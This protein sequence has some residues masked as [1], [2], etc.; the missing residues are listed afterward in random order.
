MKFQINSKEFSLAIKPVI[1][2]ATK[3][4]IKDYKYDNKVTIQALKDKII[5]F[6]YNGNA[7]IIAPISKDNFPS[8]GYICEEEGK[9]TV[10]ATN[11]WSSLTTIPP[12]DVNIEEKSGEIV[13]SLLSDNDCKR[14]HA[15]FSDIIQ[16]PNIGKKFAYE[17]TVDRTLFVKG[18]EDVV[19]APAFEEKMMTYMCMLFEVSDGKKQ[20]LRFSAGTGGRFAVKIIDGKDLI[21]NSSKVDEKIIFPKIHLSLIAKNLHETNCEKI[22]IRTVSADIQNNIPEQI[23]IEFNGFIMCLLGLDSFTKYPPLMGVINHKYTNRIYSDLKD[24]GYAIGGVSMTYEDHV[25][26]IHNTEVVFEEDKERFMVKS[27][28]VHAVSTPVKICKNDECV[29][30]GDNKKW[31]RCNSEYLKEMV[32]HGGKEGTVQ[33]NFESQS[34][35]DGDTDEGYSKMKPIL[36][37]F[38]EDID[39]S[40]ELTENFYMFFTASNK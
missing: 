16:L 36:V 33:I 8:I 20:T 25:D 15:T 31:F 11:L 5:L 9:V 28:T 27:Q 12:E 30:H 26:S 13:V 3:T 18:V 37:K 40:R 2:V 22:C 32:A 14:P 38:E 23:I 24:W 19:F 10:K 17:I 7:S 21:S 1:E 39:E 6:A 29:T 34:T 35:L 4:I